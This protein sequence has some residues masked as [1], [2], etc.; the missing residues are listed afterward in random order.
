MLYRGFMVFFKFFL[1]K[2]YVEN[3]ILKATTQ[4]STDYS[5]GHILSSNPVGNVAQLYKKGVGDALG[6][7]YKCFVEWE[8]STRAYLIISS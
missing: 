1:D 3:K 5:V 4:F 6:Y 2:K 7:L 8:Q